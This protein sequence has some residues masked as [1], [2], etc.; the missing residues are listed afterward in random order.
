MRARAAHLKEEAGAASTAA[1]E[2]AD[3][4]PFGQPILIGHHSEKRHRRDLERIHR[5]HERAFELS[6]AAEDLE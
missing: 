1:R 4:I 3:R 2:R 6:R 5:G